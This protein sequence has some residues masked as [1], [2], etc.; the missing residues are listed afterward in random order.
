MRKKN[1]L[2]VKGLARYTVLNVFSQMRK[3][4]WPSLIMSPPGINTGHWETGTI[5]ISAVVKR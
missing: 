5:L 3:K 4:M 2:A 1:T